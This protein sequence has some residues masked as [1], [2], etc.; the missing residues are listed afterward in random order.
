M[1]IRVIQNNHFILFLLSY[2]ILFYFISFHL[3]LFYF[4]LLYF[5]LFIVKIQS[6]VQISVLGLGVDFVLPLSQEQE[7]QEQEQEQEQPPTKIW[8]KDEYYRS[9]ILNLGLAINS[10]SRSEILN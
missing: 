2:F 7:Q 8:K 9:E 3:I 1:V 5:T 10:N 4:V 6:K